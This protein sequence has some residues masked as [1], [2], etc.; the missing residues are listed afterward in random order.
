MIGTIRK[1]QTWLWAVI[2]T[3]TIIS[4]VW[5]FGPS[6]KMSDVQTGTYRLGSINGE[7][8][9]KEQFLNA[10]RETA[11]HYFF[12]SGGR[13][14]DEDAKRRG[15]DLEAETYRWLLLL[16]KE[17]QFGIHPSSDSVTTFATEMLR[18]LSGG[19]PVSPAA[20]EQQIL[21]PRGFQLSDFER[22]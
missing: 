15:Y 11:L 10:Q 8:I 14:P 20:F 2:I 9:G 13:W 7:P 12:M 17:D 6:S 19:G 4:F 5:Y 1:H 3:V 21:Q 16:Q 18:Q 22:F